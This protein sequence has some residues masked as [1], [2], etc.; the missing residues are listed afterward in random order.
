MSMNESRLKPNTARLSDQ[1]S[2][3]SGPRW[4]MQCWASRT[5]VTVASSTRSASVEK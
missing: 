2:F 3:S 4:R 5:P 1:D